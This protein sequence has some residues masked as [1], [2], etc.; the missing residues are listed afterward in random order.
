[1]KLLFDIHFSFELE[2]NLGGLSM[3][4]IG[5]NPTEFEWGQYRLGVGQISE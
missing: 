1:M 5:L 2:L 3:N 4:E